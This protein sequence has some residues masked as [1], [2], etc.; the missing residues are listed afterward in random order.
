MDFTNLNKACSKDS[1]LLSRIGFWGISGYNQIYM[2]ETDREKTAFIT[3]WGLYCYKV[4]PF[5]CRNA[6]TTYQRL[7][8]K[9]FK[10]QIG[11]NI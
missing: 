5:G 6:K 3:D 8:N 2:Y 7:V 4:M 1:F 11:R 10:N 9:I